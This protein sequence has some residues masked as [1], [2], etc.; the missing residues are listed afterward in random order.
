MQKLLNQT[1]QNQT[2]TAQSKHKRLPRR[3]IR[4]QH[5]NETAYYMIAE[6]LENYFN[7]SSK[8]DGG[9]YIYRVIPENKKK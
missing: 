7:V 4:R 8:A 3:P 9:S 6:K 1:Q 2:F 5:E